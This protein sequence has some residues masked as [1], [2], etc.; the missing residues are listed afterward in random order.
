MTRLRAAAG[1]LLAA[2]ASP[3]LASPGLAIPPAALVPPMG[4]GLPTGT[5]VRDSGTGQRLLMTAAAA[6]RQ[7]TEPMPRDPPGAAVSRSLALRQGSGQ[8]LRL[9]GP[10]ANVFVADPKVA[11]VRPASATSLFV[12]GVGAGPH[13]GRR[14]GRRRHPFGAIR[15][16]CAAVG[17]S[18]ERGAGDDRA[19]GAGQACPRAGTAQGPAAHRLGGQRRPRPPRRSPIAKGFLDAGQ[20]LENQITIQ[21]LIQVTLQVR[22]AADVAHVVRN[23]GINWQA[24][25]T[26]ARSAPCTCRRWRR[27]H[28]NR[29]GLSLGRRAPPRASTSARR[30]RRAGAGQPVRTPRRT[31]PDGDERPA[32]QLPGRRRVP[33]PVG[34]RTARSPSISRISACRWTSVPTVFSDGRINIHVAPEVSEPQQPERGAP[35]TAG[36]HRPSQV[37]SLTVRRAET[38]VELG[39]GQSFAIAGLAAGHASTHNASG[40]PCLSD[41]PILGAAVP[42][43]SVQP[44]ADRAGDHGHA[45]HRAPGRTIR[46]RCTRRTRTTPR[47]PTSTGCC[48]CTRSAAPR[49]GDAGADPGRRRLRRAVRI[50]RCDRRCLPCVLLIAGAAGA[51]RLRRDLDPLQ[52]PVHLAADRRERGQHRRHGGQS[53]RPDR[54]PRQR[55]DDADDAMPDCWRSRHGWQDTAEAAAAAGSGGGRRGWRRQRRAP[56]A[57]PDGGGSYR[58]LTTP[59]SPRRGADRSADWPATIAAD[60]IALRHRRRIRRALRRPACADCGPRGIESAPRRR[61]RRHRGDAE[62]RHPARAGGRCQRRGPAADR[63]RRPVECGRAGRP[64][65]GDRRARQP[66]LLP[67]GHPRPGRGGLPAEAAD[68]RHGRAAFRRRSSLGQAPTPE[69]VLGGRAVAITGVRGGVGATTIAVNLA[70]HFGVAHAPPHRAARS[71]PAS[72]HRRVPAELQ[73]GPACA[74]RWKRRNASTR[75]SPSARRS[76]SADRLHV[77]AGEEKLAERRSLRPG[78]AERAARGAAPALQFRSSSMC[79]F[80]PVPLYRDLLDLVDQRVLVMEPTLA[81]V[82]D[83]LRLLALPH[84]TAAD[85]ARRGGA[86]PRRHSR[87]AEPAAGGGRAEDEGGRGDPRPA[88][89]GRP[90]RH[91]WASRRWPAA[92]ASAPA[93]SNWPARWPSCGCSTAADAAARCGRRQHR[94]RWRFAGCRQ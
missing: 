61:A 7:A 78:A 88:A 62:S 1:L 79:P 19:P 89:A 65:A 57:R 16:H 85:A 31:E 8:V 49:P 9:A 77:L 23:L 56:A 34:R 59:T 11:E 90:G 47:R 82:R 54:R 45:V 68:A 46:P 44:P 64:R 3:A 25:G 12:F 80:A 94:G 10:A 2:L 38:T 67:R 55:P 84:G 58:C 42:R 75:C 33:D 40:L 81:A 43:R 27:R 63:A 51:R 71:R 5:L 76:R 87:R 35:S 41:I 22:I 14:A 74:W 39:S 60:L 32:G 48:S 13:H 15:R 30:D 29:R 4:A 17:F 36:E 28:S 91:A 26:S 83:T 69:G 86:E 18:R 70:W 52:A 66:R 73:P 53:A 93:S 24:L 21:R 50:A 72:R 92:A 20:T 6:P 37:P